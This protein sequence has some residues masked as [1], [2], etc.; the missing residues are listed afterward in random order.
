MKKMVFPAAMLG[1]LLG[2][3][4]AWADATV[5]S[6]IR[7][8][9]FGGNGAYEGT[10]VTRIQGDKQVETSSIKFT[11]AV[12]SWAAG[13]SETTTITRIDKGVVWTLDTKKKTYVESPL[14]GFDPDEL[15]GGQDMSTGEEL[16]DGEQPRVKMTRSE[17][18]VQK[19]GAKQNINGFACEEYLMTWL[20]ELQDLDTKEKTTNTMKTSL[21]TT[22]ETSVIKKLQ[23]DQKAFSK[24]YMKKLGIDISPDEMQ[25]FGMGAF[26]MASGASDEELAKG[27]E[28]FKKE[29][30]KVKGYPIRT[31]VDWST[32]GGGPAA[33]EAGEKPED[34]GG[35]S[36]PTSKDDLLGGLGSMVS[37]AV[38]KK[39]TNSTKPDADEP[40]FSSTTEV[41]AISTD[42][43]SAGVFD[44]PSGYKRQQ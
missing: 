1:V 8:G 33:P 28:K 23:A 41:K 11:G 26:A 30:T 7:F 39:V 2:F 24:A 29:M 18:Q 21:W 32:E 42:T 40:F 25:R 38:S 12:L 36:I 20:V 6:F 17:F 34:S 16:D 19:T 9:G 15:E 10:T 14:A 13:K 37:K 3:S 5:E 43:V 4:C 27:F 31:M 35:F 22:P 44:I